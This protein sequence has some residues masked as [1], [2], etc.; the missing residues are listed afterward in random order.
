MVGAHCCNLE[1]VVRIILPI[2]KKIKGLKSLKWKFGICK[3]LFGYFIQRRLHGIY[4]ESIYYVP[5]AA[6]VP[7]VVN[8]KLLNDANVAIAV[9]CKW[10]KPPFIFICFYWLISASSVLLELKTLSAVYCGCIHEF[11]HSSFMLLSLYELSR[12]IQDSVL[13]VLR[14][15]WWLLMSL[16]RMLSFK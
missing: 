16:M 3:P 12:C 8:Q 13:V 10:I 11:C 15:I 1:V 5:A 6:K 4:S 14:Q 2:K 9:L 7:N